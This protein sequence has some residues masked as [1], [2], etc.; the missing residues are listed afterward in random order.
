MCSNGALTRLL[1]KG[2]IFLPTDS[3]PENLTY[4]NLI[5]PSSF[6]VPTY[7]RGLIWNFQ[8]LLALNLLQLLD[9]NHLKHIFNLYI[10]EKGENYQ[11]NMSRIKGIE[12]IVVDKARRLYYGE[13]IPGSHITLICDPDSFRCIGDM[14][15]FGCIMD[16]FFGSNAPFN[17]F[18]LLH[19][20]NA[21][22][23][24]V[25]KWQPRLNN[26]SLIS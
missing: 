11:L 18:T 16:A 3:S 22:T 2:D 6:L 25:W 21:R 1:D 14:Y 12:N 7:D 13:M 4:T 24:E 26:P 17:T 23:K 5:P 20:Q 8:S 15:L 19:L 10:Y 9:K